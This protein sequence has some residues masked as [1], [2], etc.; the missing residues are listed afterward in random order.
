MTAAR[1][2]LEHTVDAAPANMR[3]V[4]RSTADALRAR[5]QLQDE[6]EAA[7]AWQRGCGLSL[8]DTPTYQTENLYLILTRVAI[9]Q[10]QDVLPLLE[11]LRQNAEEGGR[12]GRLIEVHMLTA[13]ALQN[14][15]KRR[16]AGQELELALA[17]AEPEGYVRLFADEGPALTNA[18]AS[19]NS[20]SL[21]PYIRRLQ[22]L[23]RPRHVAAAMSVAA[24]DDL[25]QREQEVL[26]LLARGLSNQQIASNLVVSENTVKT[27]VKNIYAKLGV[28]SRTQAIAL[29]RERGIL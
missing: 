1:A 21:A 12:G 18:L 14:Q 25:S 27:H 28:T 13:L 29:G 3:D 2:M 26:R 20:P 4:A 17:M 5:W 9:A 19:V 8:Q 7:A 16:D 22:A 6:L 11:R 23:G 10:R 24:V 15:G